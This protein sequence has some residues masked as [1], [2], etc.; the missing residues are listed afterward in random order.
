[1]TVNNGDRVDLVVDVQA[2]P[3]GTNVTFD[4]LA[5]PTDV[6][7]TLNTVVQNGRARVTWT[8]DVKTRPVPLDLTFRASA[9]GQELASDVLHVA[10]RFEIGPVQWGVK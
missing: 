3:A 6:V 7:D 4:V 1:M 9:G 5:S 2:A 8:V 10:A